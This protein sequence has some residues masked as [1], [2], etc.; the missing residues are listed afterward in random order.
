MKTD[1][2]ISLLVRDDTIP[3]AVTPRLV[4]AILLALALVAGLLVS[5][6]GVRADLARAL[7]DPVTRMKWLLPLALGL[8][9]L[10]AALRLSRPQTRGSP[11]LLFAAL[12]AAA[13]MLWLVL[14]IKATP[15]GMVWP[16]IK[17]NSAMMC[18]FAIMLVSAL[19][20]AAGLRVLGGGA[21]PAPMLSGAALGLAVGSLAATLYAF[22]CT[23]DSPLFFLTWYGLAIAVVTLAGAVAGRGMLR[24]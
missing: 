12:V 23:Q 14:A 5:L 4:S 22:F 19:P 6:V 7:A 9:A 20:L 2:L 10:V 24:W 16:R 21:S 18:F 8:P 1:D 13:A 17:G 11:G 15:A 3:P